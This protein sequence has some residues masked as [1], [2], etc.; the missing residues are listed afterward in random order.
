MIKHVD[1]F[2]G[3][4]GFKIAAEQVW[5]SD[6]ETLCFCEINPFCQNVLKQNWPN[7]PIIDNVKTLCRRIFHNLDDLQADY[8]PDFVE[9]AIHRGEDYGECSCIGTDQF[10]DEYGSPDI[11][12]A[13]VPCQPSSI[14]GRRQGDSDSRW[15]WPDT[16]RIIEKL[17]PTW[18]ICE[19]PPGI[20]T[21]EKG[22]YFSEIIARFSET[23][24]DV[25]W[26]TLPASAIGAG[27]RRERTFIVAHSSDERLE[28]HTGDGKI[29]R[30]KITDRPASQA[31]I[32][33]IRDSEFWWR[34]KCP[35]P[36]VVDGISNRSF[37][38]E[39]II[40]T[41]NAIVPQVVI[42]I[43]QAIKQFHA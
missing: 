15:L 11:L 26:E 3:I 20:L 30:K 28:R 25:W 27:H 29:E 23:G 41:G 24:Y 9:C 13:G 6:L 43:M 14:I 8:D 42:P 40:A 36:V 19:Q 16:F 10:I 31:N 39:S 35:I 37:W 7:V 32:F 22:R 17:K 5:G 33:P 18:I 34:D 2:S 12:T 1:L 4:G 38:K 21:L